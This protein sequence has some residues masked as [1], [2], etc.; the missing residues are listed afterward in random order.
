M[1]NFNS[2]V[3]F[4]RELGEFQI[5]RK[6]ED[7]QRKKE[8][9]A[10]RI[11]EEESS[12]D[13]TRNESDASKQESRTPT[14]PDAPL[15]SI[16]TTVTPKR[17]PPMV[18]ETSTTSSY[19]PSPATGAFPSSTPVEETS[20]L[21]SREIDGRDDG[22]VEERD[23]IRYE[24]ERMKA[25]VEV[26][27]TVVENERKRNQS[28]AQKGKTKFDWRAKR[29]EAMR[30]KKEREEERIRN[31]TE[32]NSTKESVVK[33]EVI[34]DDDYVS[35]TKVTKAKS[36]SGFKREG[37]IQE[38]VKSSSSSVIECAD[39]V[40]DND[41]KA[42]ASNV[43][44]RKRLLFAQSPAADLGQLMNKNDADGTLVA[45]SEMDLFTDGTDDDEDMF[46]A[47][48]QLERSIEKE[49]KD[50]KEIDVGNGKVISNQVFSDK[51]NDDNSS[52]VVVVGNEPPKGGVKRCLS[53]DSP[54]KDDA[55][56]LD[57]RN[58]CN[59]PTPVKKEVT[60]IYDE[61][62]FVS[63]S[64]KKPQRRS[65]KR[66]KKAANSSWT[67]DENRREETENTV[68][69]VESHPFAVRT[70][71]V[72]TASTKVTNSNASDAPTEPCSSEILCASCGGAFADSKDELSFHSVRFSLPFS[73]AA[74]ADLSTLKPLSCL[75]KVLDISSTFVGVEM[76]RPFNETLAPLAPKNDE[77]T[78]L[79]SVLWAE[80]LG[81]ALKS[82]GCVQCLRGRRQRNRSSPGNLV[83][84]EIMND[85]QVSLTSLS[86]GMILFQRSSI[87]VCPERVPS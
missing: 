18:P 62:D 70:S 44:N 76:K 17:P 71:K 78:G 6:S 75:H 63:K 31:E 15:Y 49:E 23:D 20:T 33:Q 7:I 42:S 30:K 5:A 21:S 54:D 3:D 27:R 32:S 56:N 48:R 72:T 13:V 59:L 79:P 80:N 45:G 69:A 39:P 43:N 50:M 2:C 12:N 38:V 82:L 28:L 58:N 14:N 11:I 52:I 37:E 84:F 25:E 57:D 47:T 86:E 64:G 66:F 9:T 81:C 36:C 46:A 24:F 83:A 87:R 40:Q 22:G 73:S 26:E 77:L 74:P 51:S 67:S 60:L 16:F 4:L 1:T 53:S 10:E 85:S 61:D 41:E 19:F 29:D 55:S 68:Q 34:D 65:L 35:I 8:E